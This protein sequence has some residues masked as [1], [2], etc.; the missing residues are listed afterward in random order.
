MVTLLTLLGVVVVLFVAAAVSTRE[1]PV[2]SDATPDAADVGLPPGPVQPEDVAGLRFALAP[3]G[4]RMSEVDDVLDRLSRELADRDA[5]LALLEAGTRGT[6]AALPV[7][8]AGADDLPLTAETTPPVAVPAAQAAA[9]E[10]DA[11][12]PAVVDSPVEPPRAPAGAGTDSPQ[13]PL[14]T[15]AGTAEASNVAVPM[16]GGAGEASPSSQPAPPASPP[17][18]AHATTGDHVDAAAQTTTSPSIDARPNP[19]GTGPGT[20]GSAGAPLPS[21]GSPSAGGR[22]DDTGLGSA[23]ED[24]PATT[25][26]GTTA[27]AA[28]GTASASVTA[29]SPVAADAAPGTSAS[30]D[31]ASLATATSVPTNDGPA[32]AGSITADGP[33]TADG[34]SRDPEQRPGS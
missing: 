22:P 26:P 4:Y 32:T 6:E 28:T 9:S 29:A 7:H 18:P 12:V 11:R 34:P 25:G 13:P 20:G 27:D 24:A 14:V 17:A 33:P 2:M 30:P 19:T 10:R 23:S 31:T 1:G 16:V 21:A 15:P 8:E 3:R 5:R